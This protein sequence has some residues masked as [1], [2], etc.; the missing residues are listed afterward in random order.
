M[1]PAPNDD[2]ASLSELTDSSLL[3]EMQKRF[4]NDQIYTYIGHILLLVNPNKE[5]PIYS[6]LVSQ[7]YLSS[8]GRLCSSLPPHIFSSAER[9]YHMMLQERRP[10]CF[11]LS[12]ESGS[13]KTEA[14]KHIVK[15]LAARSCTK[16]FPLE[17]KMIQVSSILEAFGHARTETNDNS[18]RFIKLL[19]LQYCEKKRTIIRARVNTYVLE[20][21][22]LTFTPH[23][24]H[25]FNVFYLMAEGLSPEEKSAMYLNN[26]LAHRYLC[27]SAPGE[28][29]AVATA[30][31]RSRDRLTAL[32]QALRAL[33]FNNLEV[34]NLF[35]ILSAVLHLGDLRFTSLT[36]TEA[37]L[38]SDLQLLDQVSGMLQV[39]SEDLGSALTSDVQYFKGDVITRRHTVEV[40]DHYKDLLAKS[41]YSRL[42]SFLV[43]SI[44]CFL[45][46]QEEGTGDP[47]LEIGILDIFGFEELQKNGFEQL[48]I[49][50][51]SERIHQYT[52]EVLFQQ[53]QEECL[54]EG[55][56]METLH[57]PGNQCAVLD[58]FFQKPQGLLSV[59]DEESQALRPA[60]Q[61]FYK[62]LQAHLEATGANGGVN[63]VSL[64]TKDGNG[65]PP[66]KDQ[67]PSFT[68]SHYASK[69]TYD[70]AGS[71]ERNKDALPQNLLCVMKS[72]ENVV[73]HQAFQAK[74][75]QTGSLVPPQHRLKL[76]G[77]K[78]ALLLQKMTSSTS[79]TARE[80][81]KGLDISK[82]L[83]KKGTTSFLQRLERRGPVT[84]GVQLR[85]SLSEIIS[86]LQ[87][88]T[89]H[90]VQCVKPNN[91]K[92]PD[93]FDSFHVS[94]QLH[95]VGVLEMVRMIRYG[96]PVRLPFSSF[97]VRYKDL[98]D[99]ILGEKRKL[100]TEEKCR[101][102]L[103]QCKLHGVQMGRSKVFLR[104]WQA[105]H[106]SDRCH[107]LHRKIVIC[108]KVARGGWQGVM[109]GAG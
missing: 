62:K 13:G 78:A 23:N 2:L 106:L 29:A 30:S 49:N 36:D 65:N 96:Y 10:Q 98:A 47:A 27:D 7:L 87:G 33:G 53:E 21:S 89:P 86:K 50:M 39:C 70:L 99:T 40:S 22:R 64:S 69:M 11:I 107:Q 80:P 34:E 85:N 75:T 71:L 17:S 74:L 61:N 52:M 104:Y 18:S 95:Y 58:F 3:Y 6:T 68:V 100:T 20:K 5:L 81:K 12:G 67:G 24:Q 63:G 92:K 103:Q 57:S 41:I 25:N 1:P 79:A 45:Q 56:A 15:H 82:L 37:A 38:V 43:N 9:A 66:P 14:C 91:A 97:L 84:V 31:A 73:I 16:S 83:K 54:H 48:C 26:V 101:H 28:P 51:T 76:R 44:N 72:S 93:T 59:L 60:E 109:H 4:G 46:G 102:V 35:V 108:Q 55:V 90:F 32:K 19:S 105:D 94:T 42:F 88:C 8:S 77:P